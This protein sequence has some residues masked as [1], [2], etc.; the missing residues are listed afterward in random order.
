MATVSRELPEQPHLDVP[1]RESRELLDRW[2]ERLPD[3]FARIQRQHPRFKHAT[4]ATMG[5]NAFKLADAQRVVAREYGFS[6]WAEL[7]HRVQSNDSS[8]ALLLAIHTHATAIVRTMLRARPALLHIPV[9]SGTWG[10]PMSHA[11][12]LGHLDIVKACAELG[13]RD[14]QHA[15]GRA[16][17]QGEL[18]CARWLHAHG[19]KLAPGVVMGACETLNIDGFKFLLELGAPL[20]DEHGSPLA[21]LGLVLETYSRV[22]AGK[23]A[24]LKLFAQHG[25]VFPDTPMM[26]LH[27]GD[28]PRLEAL[29][30]SDPLLLERKFTLREIYPLE[31]G[32]SDQGGMNWTPIGGTTLL[33]LAVDFNEPEVF[34]WLLTSGANVNAAAAVDADGFG[35]HT[36]IFNAVV[37]GHD[38]DPAMMR[39]LLQ[40]GAST[41]VRV[42]L[43]KFIDWVEKPGWHEA[44]HVTAAEWARGFPERGWVNQAALKLL[45]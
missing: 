21:P 15:F 18:D 11:A 42:N 25:Y 43:R 9:R 45:Q 39:A 16:L 33:H 34:D 41:S 31:C 5:E 27:R 29:L 22:P 23:H 3:A 35:G 8:R 37:C 36:P 17:L 10:P 14:Y 38:D 7:K 2:R 30:R 20:T 40:H 26:A 4:V 24:I 28:I 1:K 44:H 32:C 19:A 13:A 6:D 12:N